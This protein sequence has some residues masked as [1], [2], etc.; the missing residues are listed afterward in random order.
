M[1]KRYFDTDIWKKRWFRSLSPRYKSVWWY[2]ISQCDHA[3]IFEPDV[4]IMSLFIG[5]ELDEGKI[6]EVF[7]NRIEYLDNG[8]WFIP[9]FIQFQYNA[10]TPEELNQSNRVHKSVYDKLQKYGITFRPIDEATKGH[11]RVMDGSS[12]GQGRVK[13][14]SSKGHVRVMHEAKDK[15]KDKDIYQDKD[16]LIIT[17]NNKKAVFKIPNEKQVKEYCKER[18]NSINAKKFIAFYESKGWM[19]GKNKMK[20]WQAAVRSWEQQE[21]AERKKADD[22]KPK[23]R[24]FI[25]ESDRNRPRDF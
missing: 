11:S 1:A 5:E 24:A 16:K 15:D 19:I 25:Q 23:T 17:N 13:Q 9:K 6:L 2:I 7:K 12:K 20:D 22:R 14:G 10:A 21:I 8:K 18:G 4:E 3:G